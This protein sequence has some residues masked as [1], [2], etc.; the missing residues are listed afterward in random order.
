MVRLTL[1][2]FLVVDV[3]DEEVAALFVDVEEVAAR[4]VEDKVLFLVVVE[5]LFDEEDEEEVDLLFEEVEVFFVEVEVFFVEV[6]VLEDTGKDTE[7]ITI[8]DKRNNPKICIILSDFLVFIFS[9]TSSLYNNTKIPKK[10]QVKSKK[11]C[12]L[13]PPH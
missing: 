2:K 6:F 13:P 4:L 11:K 8:P 10:N 12:Y 1:P 7:N 5:A 3:L 9:F